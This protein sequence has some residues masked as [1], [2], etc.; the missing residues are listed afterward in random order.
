MSCIVIF[1]DAMAIPPLGFVLFHYTPKIQKH[2]RVNF[3]KYNFL[4]LHNQFELELLN[5][6]NYK[7]KVKKSLTKVVELSYSKIINYKM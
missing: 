2:K 3:C 1:L 7:T 5:N 6:P 4:Q